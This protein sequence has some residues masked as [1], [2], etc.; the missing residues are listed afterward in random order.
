[1]EIL[2]QEIQVPCPK[3]KYEQAVTVKDFM[4]LKVI[5]CGGCK[6]SIA[7]KLE[8]DD[9]MKTDDSLKDLLNGFP[10]EIKIKI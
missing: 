7:L 5:I 1:M 9:P 3:C 8:G 10:K 2:D 6:N 4:N